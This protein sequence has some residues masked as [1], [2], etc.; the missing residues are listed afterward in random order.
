MHVLPVG[1]DGPYIVRQ[2]AFNPLLLAAAHFSKRE[3]DRFER[4]SEEPDLE[5]LRLGRTRQR[6]ADRRRLAAGSSG[7]SQ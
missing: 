6:L 4:D 5:S 2:P 1:Q 3:P 7:G